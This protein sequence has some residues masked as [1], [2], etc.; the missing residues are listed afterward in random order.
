MSHSIG[1]CLLFAPMV[2]SP[3]RQGAP[4]FMYVHNIDSSFLFVHITE[5]LWMALFF[6]LDLQEE[7]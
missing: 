6:I 5:F 7:H 1:I 4:F 2:L 3:Y